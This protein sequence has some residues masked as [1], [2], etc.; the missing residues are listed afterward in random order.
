MEADAHTQFEY[1]SQP[2]KAPEEGL[3]RVVDEDV[4]RAAEH[5]AGRGHT[6]RSLSPRTETSQTDAVTRAR[7]ASARH[8]RRHSCR[9]ASW[10][11]H[12]CTR[13]P[14]PASSST[15]ARLQPPELHCIAFRC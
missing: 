14:N 6:S 12:V 13:T 15:V 11:A 10:R 5:R 9:L 7:R 1:L 8:R 3:A 2:N 4:E